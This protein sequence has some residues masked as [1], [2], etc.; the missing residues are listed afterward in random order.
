MEVRGFYTE[1][2]RGKG[3]QRCG[4]D[5][6][7]VPGGQRAVLSRVSG[8]FP[9]GKQPASTPAPPTVGSYIVDV[10]SFESAAL[11]TLALPSAASGR[12]RGKK[13]QTTTTAGG[14]GGPS[15]AVPVT[16]TV[17]VIDEVRMMT[18][19]GTR[20]LRLGPGAWPSIPR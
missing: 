1:E 3:G 2:V 15:P 19:R 17:V 7:R 20:M 5:V 11:P 16:T 10:P 14:G 12:P 9:A 6:V 8:S 4:F 18:V 13:Q